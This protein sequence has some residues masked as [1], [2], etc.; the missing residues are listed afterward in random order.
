MHAVLSVFLIFTLR[1]QH[2]AFEDV[3]VP[4]DDTAL[5]SAK[6]NSAAFGLSRSPNFQG[7]VMAIIL[8]TAGPRNLD[9]AYLA[10]SHLGIIRDPIEPTFN[11]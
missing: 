3:I 4:S 2:Q 5:Y 8:V 9:A 6:R 7:R 1:L 10:L 11:Q